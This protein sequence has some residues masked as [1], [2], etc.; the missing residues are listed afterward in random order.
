MAYPGFKGIGPNK[1]GT[2]PL[3]QQVREKSGSSSGIKPRKKSNKE[4]YL[5]DMKKQNDSLRSLPKN[6]KHHIPSFDI[7]TKEGQADKIKFYTQDGNNQKL[8]DLRK[9]GDKLRIK[10]KINN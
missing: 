5:D 10:Y 6:D 4:M 2:S 3:K 7:S 9:L 8:R 1:L